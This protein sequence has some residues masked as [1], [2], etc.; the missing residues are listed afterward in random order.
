MSQRSSAEAGVVEGL[1][2]ED[3]VLDTGCSKTLIHHALMPRKKMLQGEAVTIRCAHGDNA[4]YPL[5]MVDLVVVGVPLTVEAAVSKTLPVSV[6]LGTDVPDLVRFLRTDSKDGR[7]FGG[8]EALMMVTR[9]G[10][11][12]RRKKSNGR[13]WKNQK[14]DQHR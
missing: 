9:A 1:M 11:E 12:K 10:A 2:V 7:N 3:I 6:L 14:L 8:C 5:A 13:R 4:L